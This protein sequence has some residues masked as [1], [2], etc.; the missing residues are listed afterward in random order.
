MPSNAFVAPNA[1]RF[2]DLLISSALCSSKQDLHS[3]SDGFGVLALMINTSCNSAVVA[4]R[5]MYRLG[6][7]LSTRLEC[8]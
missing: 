3:L 8:N 7:S 5:D 1:K 4:Q 6:F 2:E